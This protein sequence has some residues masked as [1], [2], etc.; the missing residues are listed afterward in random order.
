MPQK[1]KY[2][3]AAAAKT[4]PYTP[5]RFKCAKKERRLLSARTCRSAK[6]PRAVRNRIA[7]NAVKMNPAAKRARQISR[8]S[9]P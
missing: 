7:T 3:N 6:Y 8:C 1:R 9:S 4:H 2:A 5:A